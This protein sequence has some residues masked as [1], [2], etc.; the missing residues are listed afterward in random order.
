[1]RIRIR[2]FAAAKQLVGVDRV[3]LEIADGATVADLREELLRSF[4]ALA[5]VLPHVAFAVN[6]AY[7]SDETKVDPQCDIAC[8]PPVSGG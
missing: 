2:L 5:D 7:A 6:E 1:M 3:Q 8:I 4:P